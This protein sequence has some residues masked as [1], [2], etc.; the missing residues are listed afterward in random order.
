MELQTFNRKETKFLLTGEQYQ[1]LMKSLEGSLRLDPHCRDGAY[2]ICNIYFDTPDNEVLRRSAAK[3]Y[4]KEKLRLRSYG[5][6][7]S[8]HDRVFLELKRKIGGIV[9]KRRTA[10]TYGQAKDYLGNGVKPRLSSYTDLQVLSEI[11]W[12]VRNNPVTPY[13]YVSYDRIAMFGAEDRSLRI[14]LDCDLQARRSDLSLS[15]GSYGHFLLPH[16]T[17]LM[18]VKFSGAVPL[19]LARTLSELKI[20]SQGF[21]KIG[22][23]YKLMLAEGERQTAAV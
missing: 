21:S 11:D 19:F 2:R 6:P 5:T 3:P 7:S 18:E 20:Y 23:E 17:W 14:T 4:Y 1:A 15:H 9:S 13:A 10:L 16:D 8:D 22:A 12:F